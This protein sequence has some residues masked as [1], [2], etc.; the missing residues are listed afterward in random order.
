MLISCAADIGIRL[1]K[2]TQ[3][4]VRKA[5]DPSSGRDRTAPPNPP[6]TDDHL[7]TCPQALPG[8]LCGHEKTGTTANLSPL[9]NMRGATQVHHKHA[10]PVFWAHL[11]H[12]RMSVR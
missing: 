10:G 5:A 9:L 12:V 7:L 8:I 11:S 3:L 2:T 6:G 4:H 1:V